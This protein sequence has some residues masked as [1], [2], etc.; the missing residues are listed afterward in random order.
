MDAFEQ[1]PDVETLR[2]EVINIR[3]SEITHFKFVSP[4]S[5]EDKTF[6]AMRNF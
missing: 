6:P 3:V 2:W 1:V 4:P 5:E